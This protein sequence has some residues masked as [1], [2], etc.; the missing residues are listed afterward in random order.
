MQEKVG[1]LK[2]WES[3]NGE[4]NV[5]RS[6]GVKSSSKKIFLLVATC[7]VALRAGCSDNKKYV[8]TTTFY[9]P[10][11]ALRCV[12]HFS[13]PEM[14][15]FLFFLAFFGRES[16]QQNGRAPHV[17]IE[18]LPF[19]HSPAPPHPLIMLILTMEMVDPAWATV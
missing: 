3:K 13:I 14:S 6:G 10:R 2:S 11:Y 18:F 7:Y 1:K 9:P 17:S 12:C 16:E 4:H 5:A 19:L 8:F 15:N